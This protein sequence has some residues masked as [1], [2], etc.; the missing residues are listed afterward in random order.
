MR[1]SEWREVRP[2]NSIGRSKIGR[3]RRRSIAVPWPDAM[4][5]PFDEALKARHATDLYIS[6]SLVA[7]SSRGSFLNALTLRRTYIKMHT[8]ENYVRERERERAGTGLKVLPWVAGGEPP[9]NRLVSTRRHGWAAARL[10]SRPTG[11][12]SHTT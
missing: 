6:E 1:S 3:A 9:P 4:L 12:A 10:R 8:R 2:A 11:E 7:A 5:I